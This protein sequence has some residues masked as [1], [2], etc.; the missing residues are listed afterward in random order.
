MRTKLLF[1]PL[2]LGYMIF[3]VSLIIIDS[4]LVDVADEHEL[5]TGKRS[6]GIIFSVRSFGIKATA[7]VG[8]FMAGWGLEFIGFPQNA[9]VTG[10]APETING[11]LILNGP[12]YLG[13]YCL[14]IFFM[15]FYRINEKRHAEILAELEIRR[16]AAH[17][18]H[19]F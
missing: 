15:S 8:G 1:A 18:T 16:D 13:L 17:Q 12:F 5:R 10:L 6:E 9:E 14:A 3:P 7:G 2:F 11:L 19:D 4:Q